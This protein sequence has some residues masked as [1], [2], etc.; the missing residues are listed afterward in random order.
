M[1]VVGV[2]DDLIGASAYCDLESLGRLLRE[3]GRISGAYVAIDALR[4]PEFYHRLKRTPNVAGVTFREASMR[5]FYKTIAQGLTL[6]IIF[7]LSFACIIAFGVAYNA[8]RISLSER[9]RELSSLRILGFTRGESW[10]ILAG[11]QF[12]LA[13]LAIL[14]GV[15]I[16]V[17]FSWAMSRNLQTEYY[18]IPVP[19]TPS[20]VAFAIVFILFVTAISALIVRTQVKRLDLVAVLKAGD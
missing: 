12:A 18:R 15:A 5:S 20:S 8:A 4:A 2:V 14:P 7:V 10:N 17:F 13:M 19:V 9:A 11:E 3:Q 16:G 1:R 6:D